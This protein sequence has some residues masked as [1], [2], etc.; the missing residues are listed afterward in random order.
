MQVI[1][2]PIVDNTVHYRMNLN[3]DLVITN[4]GNEDEGTFICIA[5]NDYGEDQSACQ[6][7]VQG[8]Y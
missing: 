7:S 1:T 5:T 4:I 8:K 2:G 3:G 6:L